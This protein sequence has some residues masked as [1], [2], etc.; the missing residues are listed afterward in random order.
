M[1]TAG[2]ETILQVKPETDFAKPEG[3]VFIPLQYTDENGIWKPME[4][5]CL[6]LSVENGTL[7][8][9][10][11]ANAY[12]EGNYTDDHTVTY[13]GEAMAIV[14]AGKSGTVRVTVRDESRK[15]V[16]EIPVKG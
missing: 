5:H 11:S 7:A 3:L 14:R 1:R 2:P 10:G 4:K 8:G 6:S 9:L 15:Y 12:V 16:V 13:Y